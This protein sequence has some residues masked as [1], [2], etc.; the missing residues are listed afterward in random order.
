MT[1]FLDDA[2]LQHLTGK[3]QPAAQ[4]KALRMM[5]VRFGERLDGRPV[6]T[7]DAVAEWLGGKSR[8]PEKATINLKAL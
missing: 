1:Y 6:V 4:S 7:R 2:E 8:K 5:G 3:A